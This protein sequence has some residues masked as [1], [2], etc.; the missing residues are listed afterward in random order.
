MSFHEDTGRKGHVVGTDGTDQRNR[1]SN[2]FLLED[3]LQRKARVPEEMRC[4][5]RTIH[6]IAPPGLKGYMGA[7]YSNDF[8]KR[9]SEPEQPAAVSSQTQ[10]KTF[11]QKRAEEEVDLAVELVRHELH[12]IPLD[13][14]EG[15]VISDDEEGI[16]VGADK[17]L[18]D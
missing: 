6:R 13:S 15:D 12:A 4:D 10:R 16:A 5:V 8:F 2:G 7:E 14:G 3:T 11:K 18:A 9:P 17:V 1:R